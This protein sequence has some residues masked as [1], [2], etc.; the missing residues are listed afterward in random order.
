MGADEQPRAGRGKRVRAAARF[1][2][3]YGRLP[4]EF[5]PETAMGLFANIPAVESAQA[6]TLANGIAIA[7]GDGKA[8]ARAVYEMTGND[9]LAQ[10][11]EVHARMMEGM[12]NG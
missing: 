11:I 3:A 5:D 12:R 6:V 1:L 10:K 9:R 2:A 8:Q 4:N 7:F